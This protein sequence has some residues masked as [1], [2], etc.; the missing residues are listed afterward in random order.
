MSTEQTCF[1]FG[2]VMTALWLR[3]MVKGVM[4]RIGRRSLSDETP[5]SPLVRRSAH[6]GHFWVS[7][8]A[9]SVFPLGFLIMPVLTWM[10]W[11]R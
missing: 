2:V 7:T 3:G 1:L 8:V 11:Q 10:G 4:L 5:W 9:V 6:P